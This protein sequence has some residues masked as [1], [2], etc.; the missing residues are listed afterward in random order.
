[1]YVS[2]SSWSKVELQWGSGRSQRG[3]GGVGGVEEEGVR[4]DSKGCCRWERLRG[5]RGVG[6]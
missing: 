5:G 3:V 6:G 2:L 4:G 1:M